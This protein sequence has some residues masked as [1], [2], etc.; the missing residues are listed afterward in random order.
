MQIKFRTG[1]KKGPNWKTW[2]VKYC[3]TAFTD[4]KFYSTMNKVVNE[5]KVQKKRPGGTHAGIDEIYK[6]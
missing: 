3:I 4:V 6:N 2:E 5:E 1:K